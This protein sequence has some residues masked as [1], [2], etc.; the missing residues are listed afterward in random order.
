M[1]ACLTGSAIG[2]RTGLSEIFTVNNILQAKSVNIN[3]ECLCVKSEC[4]YMF[5]LP[6]VVSLKLTQVHSELAF[7]IR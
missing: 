6:P 1:S 7:H 2:D 4:V 3:M 5:T